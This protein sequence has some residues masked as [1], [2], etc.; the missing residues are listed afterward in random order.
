MVAMYFFPKMED[1]I[2]NSCLVPRNLVM[3]RSECFYCQQ[4]DTGETIID[5][6]FGLKHCNTHKP[7]AV[8]DCKAYMHRDG[9]VKISDAMK[10]PM[11]N[12]FIESL[13]SGV[14]IE[15]VTE[16]IQDF[17][18]VHTGDDWF[19]PQFIVK[20]DNVWSIPL[21]N[22]QRTSSVVVP[23][24]SI[25]NHDVIAVIKFLDTGIYI[26]EHNTYEATV[27]RDVSAEIPDE[28]FV[29]T[30]THNGAEVRMIIVPGNIQY[31]PSNNEHSDSQNNPE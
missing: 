13:K 17:W 3:T 1:P 8:R 5:Y 16:Y 4:D 23:L 24:T 29:E 18:Y 20:V 27:N 30:F 15:P 26:D 12:E 25:N 10:V 11:L 6:N 19:N 28:S 2:R 21:I 7:L 31:A 9:L 22:K 14:L